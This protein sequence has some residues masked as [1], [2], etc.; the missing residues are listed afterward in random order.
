MFDH[1]YPKKYFKKVYK[2]IKWIILIFQSYFKINS[3]KELERAELNHD[4]NHTETIF[5]H[6]IITIIAQTENNQ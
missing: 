1:V 2:S 4:S 5:S 6:K 3:G